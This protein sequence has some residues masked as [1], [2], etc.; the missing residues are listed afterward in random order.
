MLCI[1]NTVLQCC[2]VERIRWRAI[3]NSEGLDPTLVHIIW[4]QGT[5]R[6]EGIDSYEGQVEACVFLVQE[7]GVR[8]DDSIVRVKWGRS[9]LQV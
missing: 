3:A 7:N 8:P 4:M 5:D 6:L 1:Y 9:P 2:N